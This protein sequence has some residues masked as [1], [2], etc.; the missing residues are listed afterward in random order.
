MG[1]YK[2]KVGANYRRYDEKDLELAVA[3]RNRGVSL[4]KL[5]SKYG[6]SKDTIDRRA[7]GRHM[8]KAGGQT[9]FTSE[10]EKK[11]VDNIQLASVWGFPLT[12][13]D[14]RY[15]IKSYLDSSGRQV[16][17]FKKNLPGREFMRKFIERHKD[18]L[19][20]RWCENI[21][22]ARAS[23]NREVINKYFDELEVSLQG[24]EPN[25]MVNY[26]ETNITDD[27]GKTKVLVRKGAKH[28]H[29]IMDNSKSSHSIMFAGS[30][31]GELLP[32][33]IVYKAENLYKTWTE[34]GPAGARYN[35]SKN[36]WF[37][38]AIFEDWFKSTALPYFKK[39]PIESPK[40]LIGDNLA[41]H[42][43][44]SVI[45]LCRENNIRFILL[46]PNSTHIC[47]PL[48]VAYFRPLKSA[49][50]DV[51]LN[52]KLKHRGVVPK[53]TFPRLLKNCLDQLDVENKTSANLIAGFRGS[54]IHPI[55]RN[56]VLDK[57]P[58][59]LEQPNDENNFVV[60]IDNAFQVFLSN[61]YTKETVTGTRKRK[62][63]LIEPG[64]SVENT[65]LESVENTT[66]EEVEQTVNENGV[67]GNQEEIEEE[68]PDFTQFNNPTPSTS[69]EKPIISRKNKKSVDSSSDSNDSFST[70]SLYDSP[71]DF[72]E[73]VDMVDPSDLKVDD[74][75]LV[76]FSYEAPHKPVIL[77]K[78]IG[79]IIEL[80]PDLVL[81]K[82]MRKSPQGKN[83][84][85]F[86]DIEDV[87][88]INKN[89]ILS[90]LVPVFVRRGRFT[91]S[92]EL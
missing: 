77:K 27:P 11:M 5:Q 36:S 16:S 80:K 18:I 68:L 50:R 91:F 83:I 62:K 74:F 85:V 63:I 49:W 14:V 6:I 64:K 19:S 71:E 20:Q 51:L 3:E 45:D 72:E 54:G 57:L 42:I 10:E 9:V 35:R 76:Q 73:D 39:L 84:Y 13:I 79:Q 65:S 48:D 90:K 2:K 92:I 22:R 25:A 70:Q 58:P 56:K 55:N 88:D 12:S 34:N 4:R 75:I 29:R 44:Q 81:C 66:L 17:K 60:S 21:K 38:E 82:F 37:N 59:S 89:Q 8:K 26:D 86:P 67:N 40:A 69:K 1:R 46:P 30:A 31:S 28:A 78:F 53:D 24:V 32:P 7:K 23:V 87:T 33:Y 15:L 52:W 41:S 47:Q 61:L 43:S